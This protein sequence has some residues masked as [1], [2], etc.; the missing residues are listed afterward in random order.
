M[1]K[2]AGISFDPED[3][4]WRKI[5]YEDLTGR[6]DYKTNNYADILRKVI[7]KGNLIVDD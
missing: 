6:V 2:S 3:Y 4:N 7:E 5:L 1:V